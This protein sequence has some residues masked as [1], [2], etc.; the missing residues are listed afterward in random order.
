M[1]NRTLERDH[2]AAERWAQRPFRSAAQ[3]PQVRDGLSASW[4]RSATARSRAPG[5]MLW[6][7][8]RSHARRY[9][10]CRWCRPHG[11]RAGRSRR[12][13]ARPRPLPCCERSIARR[14]STATGIGSGM[15][16]RKRPTLL[17]TAMRAR[18]Q[19]VVA[20]HAVIVGDDEGA[21]CAADL[22]CAGRAVSASRRASRHRRKNR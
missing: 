21:G 22:V 17:C 4:V 3:Y 9:H 5:R 18:G 19:R 13:S 10:G 11:R 8:P 12:N 6:P 16:R 2:A 1:I 14:P 7:V 15:L 20:D